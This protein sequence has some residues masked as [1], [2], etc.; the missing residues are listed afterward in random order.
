MTGTPHYGSTEWK[1]SRA[2]RLTALAERGRYESSR[3]HAERTADV[4]LGF[5]CGIEGLDLP[6]GTHV[7][8]VNVGDPYTETLVAFSESGPWAWSCWGDE[9]EAA[10]ARVRDGLVE[11]IRD[12]HYDDIVEGAARALWL[13]AYA[14]AHDRAVEQGEPISDDFERPGPG[15][16]WKD[17]APDTPPAAEVA[18]RRL[19]HSV[20]R[21]NGY[22]TTDPIETVAGLC[23]AWIEAQHETIGEARDAV[24]WAQDL[25]EACERFGHVVAMASL[26]HGV[27]P[28]DDV[29][30]CAAY[31]APDLPL[32]ESG[33]DFP[34]P[35]GGF[36]TSGL[37]L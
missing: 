17:F 27:G 6:D 34:D 29:R 22:P 33:T 7:E 36:W 28:Y 8:Y 32:I 15:E 5:A 23:A 9:V 10:E 30:P 37:G 2:R 16:D 3:R 24:D 1:D 12:E 35:I 20:A 21:R 18:A 31:T 25:T 11:R 13:S 26:G 14:D 19:A 4:A